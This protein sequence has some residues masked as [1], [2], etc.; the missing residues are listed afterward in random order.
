MYWTLV[1]LLQE[2]SR[3]DC[4]YPDPAPGTLTVIMIS[5]RACVYPA[6]APGTLTC[7]NDRQQGLCLTPAPGTL[8]VLPISRRDF[9]YRVPANMSMIPCALN[10]LADEL[11]LGKYQQPF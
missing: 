7:Y 11:T 1:R 2:I 3:S 10:G 5:L 8:T 9:V 4:V 6:P